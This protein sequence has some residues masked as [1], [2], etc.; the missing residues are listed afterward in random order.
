MGS[1]GSMGELSGEVMGESIK[2]RSMCAKSESSAERSDEFEEEDETERIS[3]ALSACTLVV[4]SNSVG[5]EI[6]LRWI[7]PGAYLTLP[8]RTGKFATASR[9]ARLVMALARAIG[10]AEDIAVEVNHG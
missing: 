10:F 8:S 4:E 7:V 3:G 5:I 1:V 2:L 6:R 9:F